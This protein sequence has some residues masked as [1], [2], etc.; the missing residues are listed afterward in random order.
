M[1]LNHFW[2]TEVFSELLQGGHRRKKEKSTHVV[3]IE[4][5]SQ[6]ETVTIY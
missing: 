3:Q 4:V 1:K 2:K 6:I 5:I